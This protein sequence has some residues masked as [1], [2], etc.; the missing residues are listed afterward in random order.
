MGICAAIKEFFYGKDDVA[1]KPV[2]KPQVVEQFCRSNRIAEFTAR[3]TE[4]I[5]STGADYFR[6]KVK[7]D[8][9]EYRGYLSDG[10]IFVHNC[11]TLEL[12]EDFQELYL[13][14][15]ESGSYHSL[16]AVKDERR[17]HTKS[18][19]PMKR[20][21]ECM[22]RF[23]NE[24]V[25]YNSHYEHASIAR[26]F[27]NK[28]SPKLEVAWEEYRRLIKKYNPGVRFQVLNFQGKNWC[29]EYDNL[30]RWTSEYYA[31]QTL[32]NVT[33]PTEVMK[34]PSFVAK[35]F[36]GKHKQEPVAIDR[37]NK[38]TVL[39]DPI[40]IMQL[41][42][43]EDEGIEGYVALRKEAYKG[44]FTR[45]RF[46]IEVDTEELFAGKIVNLQPLFEDIATRVEWMRI[47][48]DGR[49]YLDNIVCNRKD[50]TTHTLDNS[51]FRDI[52][53][54]VYWKTRPRLKIELLS[55][56]KIYESG[57]WMFTQNE[58]PEEPT[59]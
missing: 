51:G 34:I 29:V 19:R 4:D 48:S 10:K 57:F 39:Y 40:R 54:E 41:S 18:D 27:H 22:P 25:Y 13:L 52:G 11:D 58:F 3:L 7:D 6:I 20:E 9:T 46:R 21:W 38:F 23:K 47:P 55:G 28:P 50:G 8:P 43:G 31:T 15:I 53:A 30:E 26:D 49:F 44:T 2:E 37:D 24:V 14:G 33:D 56:G 35:Y 12:L 5:L 17:Y 36:I 32:Y 45:L 16:H 1:A 42:H 59:Y